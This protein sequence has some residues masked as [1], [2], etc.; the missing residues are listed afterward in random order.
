MIIKPG[1]TTLADW[2]AI[3]EGADVA[4]DAGAWDAIDAS[5]AAVARIVARGAPVYGINTGFG[6]L[7]SVRIAD[8]ELSTLQRNIVLSHAAG[9]G[10]PSPVPVVRLM[11]AL[12]LA[13][14]GMGASGVRRETVAMLEAMLVRGLVPVVPSQG[15]VGASGDL[16]PLAHMAAAMI[17]V[18]EIELE[19]RRVPAAEALRQ[20]GLAP[21]DLG[22][23]EGLALLN[24]TQFSTA[25]ALAGL[26][27]AETI[28]RSALVTGA[29]STEAAKGSDAPFDARIHALR[30]HAG[31]RDVGDALRRL[32]AGSA[33]RASHASGDSR[34]QDPYCLRCQPQVM[35]AALDLLRQA[36]A[37]L[38]IEANGV[39]DNPLIFADSDEALSGGNFHAEPVA[40]AADMIALALCEIGS[41]SERR[42]AMLVDP[43]LS[44]L[45]AFLTPRPGL[46]SGFMIPQVTAA[47]LVS[48]NKQRAYPASVDSIPTSAN[49]EDHVS[50]AAHGA[51]RLLDMADNVSAVIAIEWL[52]ACQGI[53]FHAPLKSSDALQAA[54]MHLRAAV[55]ALEDDRHFHPDMVAATALVRTGSLVASV[56]AGLPG[57][58]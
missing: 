10:A 49:Q 13:S 5:A 4:L 28:F 33:I 11:M 29:L 14:F 43:A 31:Q 19:G 38:G 35:G 48:E 27:R 20:A 18:G 51:R 17:G 44:G 1:A 8:D 46:N 37:T 58:V 23:K 7:A 53:D 56:P 54:H 34:V 9:T 57:I 26:F 12:K 40:F 55:P 52:A 42:I 22:P 21:L 16:A 41:I 6:K 47:A 36:G 15:S 45:P 39:S 25:N 24:G 50:M 2:N 3:Y 32:M 30:G